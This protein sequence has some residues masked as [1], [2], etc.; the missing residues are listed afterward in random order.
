MVVLG[1]EQEI[2]AGLRLHHRVG[3]GGPHA[4]ALRDFRS[5]TGGDIRAAVAVVGL[6]VHVAVV[7]GVR[8]AGRGG[9]LLHRA[10]QRRTSADRRAAA[11]PGRQRLH[12][13]HPRLRRL[14][15]HH[16]IGLLDQFI[17]EHRERLLHALFDA[18]AGVLAH[19]DGGHSAQAHCVI[20]RGQAAAVGTQAVPATDLETAAVVERGDATV[21]ADHPAIRG[22]DVD[23]PCGLGGTTGTGIVEIDA[24]RK[25]AALRLER[26]GQHGVELV[27]VG[28]AEIGGHDGGAGK[29]ER[30]GKGLP[31]PEAVMHQLGSPE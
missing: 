13:R 21:A 10:L 1:R 8:Q 27:V 5:T 14:A 16:V 31:A 23:H 29:G 28:M 6:A 12:R 19:R 3:V 9:H 20:A 4:A 7:D 2:T 30:A 17:G 18:Q 11:A 15:Q 25:V 22:D 26:H 24:D